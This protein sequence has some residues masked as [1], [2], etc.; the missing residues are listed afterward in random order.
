MQT[1]F[2]SLLKNGTWN[3]TSLPPHRQAIGCKWIYKVK[4]NPDGSINK[5]KAILVA[6]EFHQQEGFG[7]HETFSP[8]VKST[9]KR[10]ILSLAL[11]VKWDIQKIDVNNAFLNGDLQ[12]EVYIKQTL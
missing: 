10:A 6:R 2:N 4:E 7:F 8:V 11:T 12:E 1:E 9:T 5:H 3:L